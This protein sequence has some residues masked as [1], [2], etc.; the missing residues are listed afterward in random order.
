LIEIKILLAQKIYLKNLT[1]NNR[2]CGYAYGKKI[3]S[4]TQAD[5]NALNGV[6]FGK[7]EL[8]VP[9]KNKQNKNW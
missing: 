2:K 4:S 7:R 5:R 6:S 1:T 8:I 9:L 3:T